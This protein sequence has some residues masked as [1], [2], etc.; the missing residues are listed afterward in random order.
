MIT[1]NYYSQENHGPYESHDI[2]N[3]ELEE[4]GTL[5]GCKLAY[6][7]FG[8]L[9]SGPSGPVRDRCKHARSTRLQS[10]RASGDGN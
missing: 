9:K 6:A 5:R 1:H 7:T 2:G 10:Q 8:T 3:F 4:G